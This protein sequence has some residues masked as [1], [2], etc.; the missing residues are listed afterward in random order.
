MTSIFRLSLY[1]KPSVGERRLGPRAYA[2]VKTV[3]RGVDRR[4]RI[5]DRHYFDDRQKGARHLVC[6]VAGD[7]P[8]AWSRVMPALAAGVRNC[9]VCVVTPGSQN[10][11]LLDLCAAR[12]WSYLCTQT[13]DSGLAQ[14]ICYRKHPNAEIIV[15][16]DDDIIVLEDSIARLIEAYQSICDDG[17]VR[18][19]ALAPFIPLDGACY[20]AFLQSVDLLDTFEKRF[21]T[22]TL[23]AGQTLVETNLAAAQWISARM[24][25]LADV[26]LRMQRHAANEHLHPVRIGGGMLVFERAFWDSIGYFPVYR[27]RLMVG[28]TTKDADS[29]YLA[30]QAT[31]RAEPILVAKDIVVGRLLPNVNDGTSASA[32]PSLKRNVRQDMAA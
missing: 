19:S 27:R 8:A 14:N 26:A 16:L 13:A 30:A 23:I 28:R 31:L 20:R 24:G 12:G 21:G 11:D 10:D 6:I 32:D 15:K 18:P 29:E 17:I 1:A 9:D 25:P 22:A 4:L 7:N 5:S 3:V 2:A